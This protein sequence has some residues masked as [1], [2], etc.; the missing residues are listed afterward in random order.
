MQVGPSVAQPAQP[1]VGLR[2]ANATYMEPF[3]NH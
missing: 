3:E 2:Y 1:I